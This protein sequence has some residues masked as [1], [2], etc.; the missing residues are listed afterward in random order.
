MNDFDIS[1]LE[2]LNSYWNIFQNT[3]SSSIE[4]FKSAVIKLFVEANQISIENLEKF[5]DSID[6]EKKV[7]QIEKE[8]D[9]Y[10]KEIGDLRFKI[11]EMKNEK[12]KYELK[13]FDNI[14]KKNTMKESIRSISNNYSYSDPCSSSGS[15]IGSRGGC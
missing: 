5:I 15:F 4:K 2:F 1:Q 11:N 3:T 9:K 7:K 14:C 12:S 13:L 10:Q 6:A 8:I